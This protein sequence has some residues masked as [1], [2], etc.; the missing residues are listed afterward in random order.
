MACRLR[1][2]VPR[3]LWL[4]G[5]V[6]LMDAS[7]RPANHSSARER[8]SRDENEILPPDHLNGVKLELDGHLNKDF[9]QEVF[10]GKDTDGFEE[11]AEPR[12]S[13]R[14]LMVIF[15][16]VDADTDRRISA[17]EMQRWIMAKSA[18][19]LREAV[20]ESRA[21]F[22]AVDPDGDGR[23]SWDEYKVKFLVS[24]GHDE[25][26]VAEK[27]RNHE[28]LKVDEETQEV[29]E[30]LKDRWYQADNPPSDL[31]LTEDE[32]LSFL[33]PEHSRGM[34]KFMVKEIVRDLDQDGD[35]LLSLSEFISLPV[36]TVENQQGQDIDDHWVRDRKRE[37]EEL[38]DAD[39][40]GIVTME[41]L[42]SYMDPMNEYSAL[43][44]AKQ[45]IAIADENQ[46]QHLEPEEVLKYSEFFTGSKL[47]D[48][49]RNVH[50]EF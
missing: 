29:L 50:E 39:H 48:Y 37:F 45:M 21:H 18:E 33:H 20:Q 5:L 32:F 3:C 8:T 2:P 4:L 40:N 30:N 7:A 36:G 17:Q 22:R 1:S 26:E 25:R 28:E 34:L 10:L 46:N 16:K 12:K 6:L 24:K 47:V 35:K 44:E 38:I 9:H 27:M 11:D 23:V 13:R 31:L 49:A 41:E 14:K 19:H 15:S 43:N 42:E